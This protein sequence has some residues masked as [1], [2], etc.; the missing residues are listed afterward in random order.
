MKKIITLFLASVLILVGVSFSPSISHVE[1]KNANT[2]KLVTNVSDESSIESDL[3]ED[4]LSTVNTLD[5]VP[6]VFYLGEFGFSPKPIDDG[7]VFYGSRYYNAYLYVYNPTDTV[8]D[9][10]SFFYTVGITVYSYGDENSIYNDFNPVFLSRTEDNRFYKFKIVPSSFLYEMAW[11][12]CQNEEVSYTRIYSVENFYVHKFRSSLSYSSQSVKRFSYTGFSSGFGGASA[13]SLQCAESA[14]TL[15]LKVTPMWY[16]AGE[17]NGKNEFTRDC[18][19]SVFFS[20]PNTYINEYGDP[21][22]FK[23]TWLN[24]VTAPYI[25]TGNEAAYLHLQDYIGVSVSDRNYPDYSFLGNVYGDPVAPTAHA[26]T[27]GYGYWYNRRPFYSFNLIVTEEPSSSPHSYG[28]GLNK[29]LLLFYSGST[30]DSADSFVVTGD[31]L[32][33]QMSEYSKLYPNN[34]LTALRADGTHYTSDYNRDLFASV[35]EKFTFFDT[36]EIDCFLLRFGSVSRNIFNYTNPDINVNFEGIPVIKEV[37]DSDVVGTD[38]S[39]S[40]ELF[41]DKSFVSYLK[42]SFNKGKQDNHY[43]LFRYK[44]SDY[45]AQEAT[46]YKKGSHILYGE[47]FWKEDTNAYFAQES[48]SLQFQII[49][50]TFLKGERYT[51][52]DVRMDPV[53]VIND[54][55]PPVSTHKDFSLFSFDGDSNWLQILL[56]LLILVIIVILLAPFLPTIARAVVFVV[57]LPFKAIKAVSSAIRKKKRDKRK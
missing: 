15:D 44:Q 52:L 35:D 7:E 57:T 47:T 41:I 38:I 42:S 30:A 55:T 53:D 13:P 36:S 27:L 17:S 29:L 50:A 31:Q 5:N 48:V 39:M 4:Y 40:N 56:G 2:S 22:A 8:F 18:L 1:A 12:C 9:D 33:K 34:K 6:Y 23:A 25:V 16:R 26:V 21:V 43:Y 20:I 28:V 49:K 10:S 37:T 19:D 32:K 46:L 51:T 14:V 11:K 24:A 3:G 54:L 45:I